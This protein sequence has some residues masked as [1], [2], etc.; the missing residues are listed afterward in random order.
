MEKTL[1]E[2]CEE[3]G[4][5]RR[6]IQG[7]EKVGLVYPSARTAQGYL[8]YDEE[9]QKKIQMIHFYQELGFSRKEIAQLFDVPEEILKEKMKKKLEDLRRKRDHIIILIENVEE[10]IRRL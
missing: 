2:L 8:L 4:V 6:A 3:L 1:K 9:A 10:R 5:S 7:Y